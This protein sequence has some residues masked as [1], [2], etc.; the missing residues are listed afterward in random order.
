[1]PSCSALAF[2]KSVKLLNVYFSYLTYFAITSFSN[3]AELSTLLCF[4][5]Y[6]VEIVACILLANKTD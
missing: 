1:M 2:I 6:E 5:L 4:V 3:F